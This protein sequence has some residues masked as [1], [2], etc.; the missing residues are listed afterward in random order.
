VLLG[1]ERKKKRQ[2][3]PPKNTWLQLAGGGGRVA[4]VIGGGAVQLGRVREERRRRARARAQSLQ[5]SSS[6]ASAT[7]RTRWRRT[8]PPPSLIAELLRKAAIHIHMGLRMQPPARLRGRAV[9]RPLVP[10]THTRTSGAESFGRDGTLVRGN[11]PAGPLLASRAVVCGGPFKRPPHGTKGIRV[12][13]LCTTDAHARTSVRNCSVDGRPRPFFLAVVDA[14]EAG[15]PIADSACVRPHTR[16]GAS[17]VAGA[18]TRGPSGGPAVPPPPPPPSP[19]VLPLPPPPS[20]LPAPPTPPASSLIPRSIAPSANASAGPALVLWETS[21][22]HPSVG[23]APIATKPS[24]AAAAATTYGGER[25]HAFV[26]LANH[27]A[28]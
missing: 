23:N 5:A 21:M 1:R 12:P 6:T 2:R 16:T 28:E 27:A 11:S 4:G 15:S 26:S 8:A 24:S 17:G 10:H 22:L 13:P 25:K 19:A 14:P 9:P 18:P 3:E 20:P 7:A